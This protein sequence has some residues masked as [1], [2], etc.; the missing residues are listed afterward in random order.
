[1]TILNGMKI[2]LK[3]EVNTILT[4]IKENIEQKKEKREI[5]DNKFVNPWHHF[6]TL[7]FA[8]KNQ[9]KI[10]V[11]LIDKEFISSGIT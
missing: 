4:L 5:I 10:I 7:C 6:N 11:L 3:K 1:M 8:S 9:I 2:R